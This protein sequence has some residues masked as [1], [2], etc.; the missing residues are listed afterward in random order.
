MQFPLI[1]YDG[2]SH[3]SREHLKKVG[4]V[5]FKAYQDADNNGKVNFALLESFV[6]SFDK[7]A[8]DPVTKADL[9]IDNVVNS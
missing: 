6:G 5:V 3:F 4:I 2:V 7:Y 8:R 1:D 9:F